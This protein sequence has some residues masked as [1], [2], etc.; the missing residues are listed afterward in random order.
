[1]IVNDWTGPCAHLLERTMQAKLVTRL[2]AGVAALGLVAVVATLA[3]GGVSAPVAAAPTAGSE[4]KA[5][6]NFQE[7]ARGGSNIRP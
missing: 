4:L 7:V 6:S 5:D 3:V 1:M 2:L